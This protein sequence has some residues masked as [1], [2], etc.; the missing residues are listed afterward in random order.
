MINLSGQ[1]TPAGKRNRRSKM[2]TSRDSTATIKKKVKALLSEMTLEEKVAQLGGA[3]VAP[4][5]ENGK[6][7]PAKA[8]KI[9]KHGI[10]HISAPAMTSGLPMREVVNLVNDIQKYLRQ[11]TQ[12]GIPAIVHEECLNGF[13]ARGATIFPQNI[14]LASTWEPELIGRI[15]RVIRR[16]MRAAGMHQG[17]APVLDVARDPRWGRVEE[18]FGEDPHLVARM[19]VAYIKDLQGDDIKR[20]IVATTKHFAGHGLPESGLNCAPSHIPPRLF[21]EVFLY[22]FEKAVKEAGVLSVMNA[23]HEIDGI[24]CA[25]S[26]EL[27]TDILRK[28]WGFDGVVVSD[29]FAIA[30]LETIHR[31]AADKS[32]AAALSLQAGLD[33]ELPGTDCYGEPLLKAV[34]SGAVPIALVDR[35]VACVLS[36]KFRLGLFEN[37]YVSPAAAIK[38]IDTPDDRKLAREAARKSIILMKNEGNLLPLKKNLRS[39]AVIGPSAASQRNLLGDYTYPAHTR[40]EIKSDKKTGQVQVVFK[41]KD[42]DKDKV[43][44]LKVVTVLEG[45]KGAVSKTTK[46]VYARGCEV[47]D[48][49]KDGFPE[50]VRA[51]Q[52]AEVAVL[53]CGDMSGL[54]PDATSGEMRDR[55]VLGLPGVQEELVKA[56][57]ETGTPV[58][59]VLVNGRPYT[60]KWLA[61][62]IPAIIVA[63][64]PGEEGGRAV[65]DVLFGDYNPGGKLPVSFPQNEG[66]L[67]V[68][69]YRKPSGRKSATWGDYVD[70]SADPLYE[71]GYGLSYTNFKFSDL[72]IR[73]KRVDKDGAVTIK[74]NVT[75]TG[76]RAGEEVV[77]LYINDVIASVTRPVKELKGFD[78]IYLKS[79]EKKTVTFRIPADGLAFYNKKME[80]KVEPGVFKV[81]IGH[82]SAGIRLE[83][84][85]EV[86]E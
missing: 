40:F 14:G 70:G 80:R 75:N 28:E 25:A 65:A 22:P 35:A 61:E 57:Y 17:L 13:R 5:I 15:T 79:G 9:L 18:T 54:M 72:I 62:K 33:V 11:D 21:R 69:Y 82:S 36:L 84:E 56:V 26:E 41:D 78:R 1:F 45:I 44:A 4:L 49:S 50:A 77:Q 38:V 81:M 74:A 53:V 16:Q 2:K 42:K 7:A 3:F 6:F 63:W 60:L 83:G 47:K 43:A 67:P 31:T 52:S 46:V 58:V 8:G 76:K 10:G 30:Q 34:K 37:T 24:P 59:L 71:F 29:Y 20:G 51:A 85:F 12:L 32:E 66:Q 19:G 23:Y 39:I 86:R 55:S 64:E 68:Y 48:V 73:P 27:L